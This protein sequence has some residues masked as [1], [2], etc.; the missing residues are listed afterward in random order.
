MSAAVPPTLAPRPTARLP[1][2][3]LALLAP[4]LLLTAIFCRAGR[5]NWLLE[6]APALLGF[7]ALGATY[8]RFRFT[9]FCYVCVFLHTLILVY[10]GYYTYA[11]TPLGNWARD[12]FH[13][14]RNHYDR[15]GHLALGFFP[16]FI[17][18][19]TLLRVTPLRRGG[20]L[21]F[22]VLSVVLA[23]AAFYELIEWWSTYLVAPDAGQAFLGSQGD[24]WDAQWDMFLGLVGG[25]LGLALLG[26]AHDRAMARLLFRRA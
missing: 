19:E 18:K 24:P 26:R 17:I 10:G 4:I 20:W 5:L 8:R 2:G 22:L 23:I 21:T 11:A 7:V 6:V 9:N 25:A 14:A 16:V 1:L 15:V 3:L 12:T 13:L